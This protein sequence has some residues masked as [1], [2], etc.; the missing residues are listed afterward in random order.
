MSVT[1][2]IGIYAAVRAAGSQTALAD[3]IGVTQQA[4]NK[5]VRLGWVPMSRAVEIEKTFGVPCRDL[6]SPK[7]KA[8][9]NTVSPAPTPDAKE[10]APSRSSD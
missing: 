9:I 3:R 10:K 1:T 2:S 4:I 6:V 5:W 8:L 7:L